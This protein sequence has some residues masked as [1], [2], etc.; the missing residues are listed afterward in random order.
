MEKKSIGAAG[1]LHL[2]PNRQRE[3][4]ELSIAVRASVTFI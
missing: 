3:E 1:K 2:S 4:V